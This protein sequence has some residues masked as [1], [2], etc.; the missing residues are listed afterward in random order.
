MDKLSKGFV[1]AVCL[2]GVGFGMV[3]NMICT[4]TYQ[5]DP[6]AFA[7]AQIGYAPMVGSTDHPNATLRYLELT[8]R[9][10]EPTEGQYAWDAIEQRYGLAALREQ[11]IHLVLRFVYMLRLPMAAGTVPRMA[12]VIPRI[13]QTISFVP[14]TIKLFQPWPSILTQMAL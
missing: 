5:E 2:L 14:H 13:M 12:K 1:S 7:N 4:R 6:S 9:E 10:V 3:R 8:W 11:G